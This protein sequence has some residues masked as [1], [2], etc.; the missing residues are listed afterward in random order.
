MSNKF[1]KTRLHPKSIFTWS[2]PSMSV[3]R[4]SKSCWRHMPLSSSAWLLAVAKAVAKGRYLGRN[5]ALFRRRGKQPGQVLTGLKIEP[6]SCLKTGWLC[7][8]CARVFGD[9]GLLLSPLLDKKGSANIASLAFRVG[10][11]GGNYCE[12]NFE[13]HTVKENWILFET[14]SL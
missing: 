5:M 13:C 1:R 7:A 6:P 9:L 3:L 11:L 4:Q 12:P 8:Q 14:L 2:I 10:R